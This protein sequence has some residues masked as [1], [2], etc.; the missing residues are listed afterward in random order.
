MYPQG[1]PPSPSEKFWVRACGSTCYMQKF[2]TITFV[3]FRGGVFPFATNEI[4]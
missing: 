3:T 4:M 2:F 1:Q